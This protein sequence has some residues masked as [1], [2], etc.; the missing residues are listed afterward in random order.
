MEA[1]IRFAVFL[2]VFALLAWLEW[3]LPRRPRLHL[4]G[5]RWPTNLGILALDVV[6]QRVTVGAVAVTAAAWAAGH[7]I[8]LLHQLAWP[9]WFEGAL[10]FL[11]L[12][13]VIWAQHV[14]T[15][16]LPMLWRLHQVHHADLDVDI[17]TGLRFHPVEIVLSSLLKAAVVVALGAP[18]LAVILFEIVLNASAV[19]TH[20]NLRIPPSVDTAL[21]YLICT[22]DMHRVHHSIERSETDSNYGFFLSVWDRL[23]RTMRVAPARGQLGVELGLVGQRDPARLRLGNL[24]V[25][26]FRR[27]SGATVQRVWQPSRPRR[28]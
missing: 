5:T 25:M 9:G 8:G 22:P 6:A 16:R 11:A 19:F 4:R 21:R 3:Y 24:L 14:A 23:F 17:T 27:S 13:L 20:A 2:G 12:D 15:H 10:A 7:Q 28:S 1:L 26:P 18:T